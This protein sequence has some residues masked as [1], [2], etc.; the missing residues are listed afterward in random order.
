[1]ATGLV[2][3][4]CTGGG[5]LTPTTQVAGE[6]PEEVVAELLE[7]LADGRFEATARFT[8]PVQAALLTLAEG[9]D[10]SE[11]MEVIEGSEA[12]DVVANFWAGFAQTLDGALTPEETE[13]TRAEPVVE[14][15]IEFAVVEVAPAGGET[16]PFLLRSHEGW[17]ID[18]FATFGPALAE[19]LIPPVE[20]ALASPTDEAAAVR[21][22]LASQVT[23]LQAGVASPAVDPEVRQAVVGLIE[24]ITRAG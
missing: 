14:D 23:S 22:A 7:I 20:G 6:S 10:E 18:L 19:S 9:R 3:A 17:Q 1:M 16:R 24:R 21:S 2:L 4:G 15:G 13:V 11:V 8:D 5:E 12:E